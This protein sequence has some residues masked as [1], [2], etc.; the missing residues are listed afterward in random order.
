MLLRFGAF[1]DHPAATFPASDT[2]SQTWICYV[3]ATDGRTDG[4]TTEDNA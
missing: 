3:Y 4:R 1:L 2:K